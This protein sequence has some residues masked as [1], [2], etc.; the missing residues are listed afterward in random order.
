MKNLRILEIPVFPANPSK[1]PPHLRSKGFS[2]GGEG[3]STLG[4]GGLGG[5]SRVEKRK[6]LTSIKLYGM[7]YY[8]IKKL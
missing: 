7:I 3:Y 8:K 5:F 1:P 6:D 2:Q 4:N